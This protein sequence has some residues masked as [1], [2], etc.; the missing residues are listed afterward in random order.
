MFGTNTFGEITFGE[1]SNEWVVWSL[2][3]NQSIDHVISLDPHVLAVQ[4]VSQSQTNE[5]VLPSVF[6]TLTT[7]GLTQIQSFPNV[8]VNDMLAVNH[9]QQSQI[10]TKP[11]IQ[12]NALIYEDYED[13]TVGYTG[14][15]TIVSSPIAHGTKALQQG[16]GDGYWTFTGV[17]ELYCRFYFR[18]TNPGSTGGAVIRYGNG[19]TILGRL[20]YTPT[21]KKM[22]FLRAST[23]VTTGTHN[24][25]PDRWYLIELRYLLDNSVGVFHLKINS[26]DDITFNGDT[27]ADAPATIDRW[28]IEKTTMSGSF[29][30]DDIVVNPDHWI[31]G[32]PETEIDNLNQTQIIENIS[33]SVASSAI[34]QDLSQSQD[35]S[36]FELN[37]PLIDDLYQT[38]II[39]NVPL[40][41]SYV[42]T[43]YSS[44]QTST[45]ESTITTIDYVMSGQDLLQT[46]TIAGLNIVVSGG[47]RIFG[48]ALQSG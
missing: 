39:E 13:N 9:L 43:T 29:Y 5:N 4:N 30:Y 12:W 6:Y 22:S 8:M 47:G 36:T 34:I 48:P 24:I 42:I 45:L 7:Q 18:C 37:P 20:Y 17:T 14:G 44:F 26:E 25:E 33:L 10:A 1:S 21:T 31:G 28:Y 3:Q 19:T 23:I 15:G 27:N 16:L 35:L 11:I 38:P 32:I 46:Q 2:R 41:I 40:N